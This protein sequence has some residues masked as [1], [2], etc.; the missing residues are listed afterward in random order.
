MQQTSN[1]IPGS[2]APAV[3]EYDSSLPVPGSGVPAIEAH[4]G[5]LIDEKPVTAAPIDHVVG[6]PEK[7]P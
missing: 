5:A 7:L 6:L 2:G 4:E 3:I 1:P